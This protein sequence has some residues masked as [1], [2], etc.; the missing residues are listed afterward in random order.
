MK[1]REGNKKEK[2]K[3]VRGQRERR[4]QVRI[5]QQLVIKGRDEGVCVGGVGF[6]GG[7]VV[8]AGLRAFSGGKLTLL[9][10]Y[11]EQH[12]SKAKCPSPL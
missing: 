11:I 6:E 5:R 4:Y 1:G 12:L 10:L 2:E 9:C 8:G 3:H 7:G